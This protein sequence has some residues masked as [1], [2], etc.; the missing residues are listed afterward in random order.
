M[1]ERVKPRGQL[2]AREVREAGQV[3][4]AAPARAAGGAGAAFPHAGP[5]GTA[6]LTDAPDLF[7]ARV[8]AR[9]RP[10][11]SAPWQYAFEEVWG[12]P[13]TGAY[14]YKTSGRKGTTAANYAVAAPGLTFAA[15][16]TEYAL[17]RRHPRNPN[18]YEALGAAGVGVGVLNTVNLGGVVTAVSWDPAT[19]VLTVTTKTLSVTGR[20][21]SATLT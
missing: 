11:V 13:S 2:S 18:L 16:G 19:C 4:E 15:D 14:A 21:L 17:L 10:S 5:G 3:L 6:W 9:D 7:P 20:D 8:T 1:F 12:D